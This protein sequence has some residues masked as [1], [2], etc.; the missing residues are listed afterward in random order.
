MGYRLKGITAKNIKEKV[1]GEKAL[2][3]DRK[4]YN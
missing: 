4:F 3:N 2:E 1:D